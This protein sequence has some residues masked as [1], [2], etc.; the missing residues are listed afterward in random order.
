[1]KTPPTPV[2]VLGKLNPEIHPDSLRI[3]LDALRLYSEASENIEKNG[4]ITGHPKT[5]APIVNPYMEI[6][7]RASRVLMKF[8]REH[9]MF[10]SGKGA[11]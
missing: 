5:G 9:P 2:Q 1:M 4:A 7:E 8:H 10:D 11:Q 6:Q 3:Y